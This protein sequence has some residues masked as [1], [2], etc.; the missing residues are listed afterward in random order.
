MWDCRLVLMQVWVW[1][2]VVAAENPSVAVVQPWRRSLWRLSPLGLF[3]NLSWT[4]QGRRR[5]TVAR[6]LVVICFA[7]ALWPVMLML[8][9]C[10]GMVRVLVPFSW[11]RPPDFAAKFPER[12]FRL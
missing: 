11:K 7:V 1:T 4:L 12:I 2:R 3:W 6:S 9:P 8:V 10:S 5:T